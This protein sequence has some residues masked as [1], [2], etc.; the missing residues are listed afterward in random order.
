[1][2]GGLDGSSMFDL[3]ESVM[4]RV[5]KGLGLVKYTE[6]TFKEISNNRL[7]L[8]QEIGKHKKQA[9]VNMI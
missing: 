5:R 7:R 4:K 6:K 2:V 1:M 3:G 9:T 8:S